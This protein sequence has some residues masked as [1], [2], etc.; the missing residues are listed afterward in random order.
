[1]NR[2]NLISEISTW[3]D[4]QEKT[5]LNKEAALTAFKAMQRAY[6]EIKTDVSHSE[7][8]LHLIKL[9]QAVNDSNHWA[10]VK[11]RV[12]E[13]IQQRIAAIK[14]A[15]APA[16]KILHFFLTETDPIQQ[17]NNISS[18]IRAYPD[19]HIRLW[20][21]DMFDLSLK[22]FNVL[23]Q[24]ASSELNNK[25]PDHD[26]QFDK[27]LETLLL[28]K[29]KESHSE[30]LQT[31]TNNS[32]DTQAL[33]T[34]LKKLGIS[35][36]EITSISTDRKNNAAALVLQLKQI[37]TDAVIQHQ[38]ITMDD[39]LKGLYRDRLILTQNKQHA[40]HTLRLSV[41]AAQGG[42]FITPGSTAHSIP[43]EK[44]KMDGSFGA[45]YSKGLEMVVAIKNSPF[46]NALVAR[47]EK[48]KQLMTAFPQIQ[49]GSTLSQTLQESIDSQLKQ[50]KLTISANELAGY[51]YETL[52]TPY[53][54]HATE[55]FAGAGGYNDVFMQQIQI[56]IGDSSTVFK[57]N[58]F[59][60]L[61]APHID[62]MVAHSAQ[63]N[64][65][66][67]PSMIASKERFALTAAHKNATGHSQYTRQIVLQFTEDL[68]INAG[69]MALH[70]KN[71][72]ISSLYRYH[73]TED[74]LITVDAGNIVKKPDE[75]LRI[76]LISHGSYLRNFPADKIKAL[77]FNHEQLLVAKQ[78]LAKLSVVACNFAQGALERGEN[79]KI[80]GA[81]PAKT[82]FDV[83]DAA[84]QLDK[85][86]IRE[87][88]LSIDNNGQKWISI[89]GD[90]TAN[91]I[92]D[93]GYQSKLASTSDERIEIYKEDG[94]VKYERRAPEESLEARTKVFAN[95]S[96]RFGLFSPIKI[97]TAKRDGV[98]ISKKKEQALKGAVDTAIAQK[99]LANSGGHTVINASPMALFAAM[100]DSQYRVM[101]IDNDAYQI[102]ALQ[103]ALIESH[104]H[105]TFASWIE[106]INLAPEAKQALKTL[107]AT[108]S[109]V[110][111]QE[112]FAMLHR[113]DQQSA[114]DF[115]HADISIP[116]LAHEMVLYKGDSA[117]THIHLAIDP[118]LAAK[119]LQQ[120]KNG[121][122]ITPLPT[123][124]AQKGVKTKLEALTNSTR[125]LYGP[126]SASKSTDQSLYLYSHSEGQYKTL[127]S[128]AIDTLASLYIGATGENYDYVAKIRQLNQ[129]GPTLLSCARQALTILEEEQLIRALPQNQRTI[130]GSR[131]QLPSSWI[132]L[133]AEMTYDPT[134][135]EFT[136]PYL[137]SNNPNH[138]ETL[139]TQRTDFALMKQDLDRQNKLLNHD[140]EL[141]RDDQLP[142]YKASSL[143]AVDAI[144][145]G[146]SSLFSTLAIW[147][148]VK[149]G[150]RVPGNDG[151]VQALQLHTYVAMAEVTYNLADDAVT[152]K[153][154]AQN[155]IRLSLK[156]PLAKG[157][158]SNF[159][160]GLKAFARKAGW[161][162]LVFDMTDIGLSIREYQLAKTEAQAV[163]FRTEI[164]F[165]GISLVLSL[166]FIVA[167][168]L[169]ATLLAAVLL[170]V[171][172]LL[173]GI[174][175]L[176]GEALAKA[177]DD[178]ARAKAIGAYF[179]E[180]KAGWENGGFKLEKGLLIPYQGVM[181]SSI[182]LRDPANA[183]VSFSPKGLRMGR[184]S[185][186]KNYIDCYQLRDASK[187]KTKIPLQ[188]DAAK[189]RTLMLP[190][191]AAANVK[192]TYSLI[193]DEV[194]NNDAD[195]TALRY[196][197]GKK[198]LAFL[199]CIGGE[200]VR[201]GRGQLTKTDKYA[202][203]ALEFSYSNT[204]IDVHLGAHDYVLIAPGI[205][206]EAS[207]SDSPYKELHYH[208][209]GPASGNATVALV[210]NRGQGT[211]KIDCANKEVDWVIEAGHLSGIELL[212]VKEGTDGRRLTFSRN[213]I[214]TNGSYLS[215]VLATIVISKHASTQL[216]IQLE[217]GS[218]KLMTNM[219]QQSQ[220]YPFRRALPTLVDG[221]HGL[222]FYHTQD[223]VKRFVSNAPWSG[224]ISRYLKIDNFMPVRGVKN[225]NGFYL[226]DDSIY[227]DQ[228]VYTQD[229]Q[230]LKFSQ[231][232]LIFYNEHYVLYQGDVTVSSADGKTHRTIKQIF[233]ITLLTANVPHRIYCPILHLVDHQEPVLAA[234]VIIQTQVLEKAI[235]FKQRFTDLNGRHFFLTYLI[236]I[237]ETSDK[238]YLLE[239]QGLSPQEKTNLS[240]DSL[241]KLKT[242]MQQM[243]KRPADTFQ[244]P[245]EWWARYS[246]PLRT[247]SSLGGS[248]I[249]PELQLPQS[250]T[251]ISIGDRLI[252]PMLNNLKGITGVITANIDS[253]VL[254]NGDYHCHL[255]GVLREPTTLD[256][257][258]FWQAVEINNYNQCH[259]LYFQQ[260][261][262]QAES[263]DLITMGLQPSQIKQV[264]DCRQGVQLY[265]HDNSRYYL[266]RQT[267][268]ASQQWACCQEE[269]TY[270]GKANDQQG[271]WFWD[272]SLDT[273]K[274]I[275][276]MP[277]TDIRPDMFACNTFIAADHPAVTPLVTSTVANGE[278]GKLPYGES[279]L[280]AN[281]ATS[282]HLN[283]LTQGGLLLDI[284][285]EKNA[286]NQP[287][288]Q[289]DLIG[290]TKVFTD[291]YAQ[292]ASGTREALEEVFTTKLSQLT[293]PEIIAIPFAT[294]TYW[295]HQASNSLFETDIDQPYLGFN[296]DQQTA[297]FDDGDALLSITLS[298]TDQQ[299]SSLSLP[300]SY[301][302][303]GEV[304]IF[305]EN[306]IT[307]PSHYL[308]IDGITNLLL[309]IRGDGNNAFTFEPHLFTYP[310]IGL[311]YDYQRELICLI[312]KTIRRKEVLMMQQA[313]QLILY[314][315]KQWLVIDDAFAPL[316]P[317]L[318]KL[319]F[320]FTRDGI[321]LTALH[322]VNGYIQTL[323]EQNIT[324]RA[325][326]GIKI[327]IL[328]WPDI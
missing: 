252:W 21:D 177:A 322:L 31:I 195:F 60:N 288:L 171:S 242:L 186:T 116:A 63:R 295:Y 328:L 208:L 320:T 5:G 169:G 69:A 11:T 214:K 202:P 91:K 191:T 12:S 205:A 83:F 106:K 190:M 181:I 105:D 55:F 317:N 53:S 137:D 59:L 293:L 204:V 308:N 232:K 266:Y 260:G 156:T 96:R 305:K 81:G 250:T 246:P 26:Y 278:A 238:L 93:R 243:I 180:M 136:L 85:M 272:H 228:L 135:K 215:E 100:A 249:I 217:R 268:G 103:K 258:Y 199:Y 4:Q 203:T 307:V 312:E 159:S 241:T 276:Y 196:F 318:D 68:T 201:M 122:T 324:D 296:S 270:L 294:E 178:V 254:N 48:I 74:K 182:D 218:I 99:L 170:P 192:P 89:K 233:W 287:T 289:L 321:Q 261:D 62:D 175:Y 259:S 325:N 117:I 7:E 220:S 1:M 290:V 222:D 154:L 264:T 184:S 265:M 120:D 306:E 44:L 197:A 300:E 163:I 251:R 314:I 310:V 115:F 87:G 304:L 227:V 112:Y 277:A 64:V 94:I 231:A 102:D 144:G 292:H 3:I 84:V 15:L 140:F 148:W 283:V 188:N 185:N 151:L 41:L 22:L 280:D 119:I 38:T 18:W 193:A 303:Q 301:Q 23:E 109:S 128:T 166:G 131:R 134:S 70:R 124:T 150:I 10:E 149:N 256:H 32:S 47:E 29:R 311:L 40:I 210:L 127:T 57:E 155:K 172:L 162:G 28:T 30:I 49:Q 263:I 158:I 104:Y 176:V 285:I 13:S 132:P 221:G 255:V 39:T 164:I 168:M 58:S 114:Y 274:K 126:S 211:V 224:G 141:D 194:T 107:F 257:G 14:V 95:D 299:L 244:S 35:E 34:Y 302:R 111:Q 198:T 286:Q 66:P 313:Q 206:E 138:R 33:K 323:D 207:V 316:K 51:A 167:G 121:S 113:R 36:N 297:Y 45:L 275:S 216:S 189:I 61:I 230:N 262:Q 161:I 179:N 327:P 72:A 267:E 75:V 282:G 281:V 143:T 142:H 9:L 173:A 236:D 86:S 183:S 319:K 76:I 187:V 19:F 223:Y 326:A 98:V 146:V 234:S 160:Q 2:Q 6:Q 71:K 78:P 225:D 309:D 118:L 80:L 291:N 133:L 212:D 125:I 209:K 82:L 247:V 235:L 16:E 273:D 92:E 253:V 174:R 25:L 213:Q 147:G 67:G 46:I 50:L 245:F 43:S 279:V 152:L 27:T 88:Y 97:N 42:I 153:Q 73:A 315:G 52:R 56:A 17:Y 271:V 139:T 110:D 101:V 237:L 8:M 284:H 24:Q 269:K 37:N 145:I 20:T 165:G 240:S 130:A 90:H 65:D 129:A 226:R 200:T 157:S 248:K 79:P 239:V 298:T 123:E 229:T 54:S 108:F 77:L 219:Q